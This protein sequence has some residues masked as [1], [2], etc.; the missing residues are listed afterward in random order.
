MTASKRSPLAR[1]VFFM[2]C[3]SIAGSLIAGVYYLDVDLPAQQNAPS[4]ENAGHGTALCTKC[5]QDCG[6]S[7]TNSQYFNC[8]MTCKAVAC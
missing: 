7:S 3:L 4:P 8:L 2:V 1:L 5:R 6:S